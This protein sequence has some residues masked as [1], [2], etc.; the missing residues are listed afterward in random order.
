MEPSELVILDLCS[1]SG[2]WSKPYRDNGYKTIQVDL[3]NGVDVRLFNPQ[4]PVHGILAAPPCTIFAGSGA[5]WW[6][7][8]G[9]APLLEGLS[10]VDACLR[11]IYKTKPKFWALENPVGRLIHYLGEPTLRFEPWHYGDPYTKY[12]LL[13]G[14]FNEP[15]PNYVNP[16]EGSKMH[17]M[18][19]SPDRAAKRSETS[20][21]FAQ[22]FFEANR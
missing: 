15:I 16:T 2:A 10:M 5:R 14:Q 19:P 4:G 12:T 11:I 13:W 21:A 18:G 7:E 8:K 6:K 9:E 17:K 1:G 20:S 3:I 22:A